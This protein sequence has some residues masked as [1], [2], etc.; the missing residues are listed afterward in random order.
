[1]RSYFVGGASGKSAPGYRCQPLGVWTLNV[2]SDETGRADHCRISRRA[3]T[4]RTTATTAIAPRRHLEGPALED[5]PLAGRGTVGVAPGWGVGEA[6]VPAGSYPASGGTKALPD[7]TGAP[8]PRQTSTP[9]PCPVQ[10]F[11]PPA[12]PIP[13]TS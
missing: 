11:P 12:P 7:T 9:L 4:P 3:T 5:L 13:P 6:T 2:P 8:H 1:M 10:H